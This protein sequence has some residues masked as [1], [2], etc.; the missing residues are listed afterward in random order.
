M[1]TNTD[2]MLT[3]A[4]F[5]FLKGL[6]ERQNRATPSE[7]NRNRNSSAHCRRAVALCPCAPSIDV[8]LLAG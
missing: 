1:L 8:R 5:V 3:E 6:L 7:N 4:S 2:G